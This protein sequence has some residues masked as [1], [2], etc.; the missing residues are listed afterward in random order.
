VQEAG[1]LEKNATM[2]PMPTMQGNLD[3]TERRN[4]MQNLESS[5]LSVDE[6]GNI[7]PK[8]LEAALVTAHVYLLTTQPTPGDPRKG[9]HL[10]EASS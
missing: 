6:Q 5:F 2:H 1:Q 7:M 3:H 9:M 10:S 8:M 4:F